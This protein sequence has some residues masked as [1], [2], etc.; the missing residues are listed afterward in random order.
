MYPPHFID[1]TLRT[2]KLLF[3]RYNPATKKWYQKVVAESAYGLDNRLIWIGKI[4][5]EE[6]QIDNFSYWHDRLVILKEIFDEALPDTLSQFW[7]DRRNRPLWYAFWVALG[8]LILAILTIVL[9]VVQCVEGGLQV[10][11]ALRPTS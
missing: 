2:L 11:L 7:H 5:A 1:E 9:A 6:R 4:N 8:A 10:F 3:P